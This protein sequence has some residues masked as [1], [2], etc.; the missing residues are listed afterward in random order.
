MKNYTKKPVTIQALQ[1][2]GGNIKEM[3]KFMQTEEDGDWV[4][5]LDIEP[6]F[7]LKILTLEGTHWIFHD[8]FLHIKTLEGIMMASKGDFIIRG[9]KGEYYPCKPDIFELTYDQETKGLSKLQEFIV[10]SLEA[11]TFLTDGFTHIFLQPTTGRFVFMDVFI[12][13]DEII[14]L[15]DKN[16]IEYVGIKGHQGEQMLSYAKKS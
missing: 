8:S 12:P 10:Y 14:D 4:Q 16:I 7:D 11:P 2:N 13:A 15:I 1:W 6:S 9:I 5:Y 3:A